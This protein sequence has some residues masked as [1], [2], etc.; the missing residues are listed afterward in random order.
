MAE[1]PLAHS[2]FQAKHTRA[3]WD[4]PHGRTKHSL[5]AA[6]PKRPPTAPESEDANPQPSSEQS[7]KPHPVAKE[8]DHFTP[9][10]ESLCSFKYANACSTT[11]R[12][13][14]L[15]KCATGPTA[16]LACVLCLRVGMGHLYC[17]IRTL[18]RF[19]SIYTQRLIPLP[20][21]LR[22]PEVT[23]LQLARSQVAD[24]ALSPP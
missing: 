8:A 17:A 6:S 15:T 5:P 21:S 16:F 13:S 11:S 7:V 1:R 3:A 4:I 19:R 23:V 24:P 10:L 22:R 20:T 2:K 12:A 18:P 9:A 14:L